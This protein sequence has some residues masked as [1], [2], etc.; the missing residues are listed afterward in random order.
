MQLSHFLSKM[1]G[2]KTKIQ[3]AFGATTAARSF[4]F[5]VASF[6]QAHLLASNI[7]MNKKEE[8]I[9]LFS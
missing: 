8:V 5:D 3:A 6:C 2:E 7:A 1:I 9:T 4:F